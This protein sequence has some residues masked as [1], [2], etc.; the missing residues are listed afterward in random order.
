MFISQLSTSRCRVIVWGGIGTGTPLPQGDMGFPP[1]PRAPCA[2]GRSRVIRQVRGVGQSITLSP[3]QHP[4]C[5][6]P[7][8]AQRESPAGPE[9]LKQ[10]QVQCQR[11]RRGMGLACLVLGELVP[12]PGHL[13]QEP[14]H[15]IADFLFLEQMGPCFH[16]AP[17]NIGPP[18]SKLTLLSVV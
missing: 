3:L 5:P 8:P 2:P 18:C 16:A 11:Q 12:P 4:T 9:G 7:D 10:S 17:S 6:S 15:L 13:T 1:V 14:W